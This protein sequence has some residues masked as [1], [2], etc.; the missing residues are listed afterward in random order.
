M[1]NSNLELNK[2]I[3]HRFYAVTNAFTRAY[4]PLLKALDLTYPQYIAMMALWEKDDV[5][6]QNL[7]NKTKIDGGTMSLILKKLASKSL[8]SIKKDEADGRV[9]RVKLTKK[10]QTAQQKAEKIPEKIRCSLNNINELEAKELIRLIDKI[11]EELERA[12]F[13]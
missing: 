7:L 13:L 8:L 4:R 6:I 5:T 2:Q 11:S 1:T 10:G 3:C 9:K 12:S